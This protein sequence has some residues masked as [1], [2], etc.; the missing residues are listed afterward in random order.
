MDDKERAALVTS[1]G[2]EGGA[3]T[4]DVCGTEGHSNAPGWTYGADHARCPEHPFPD[5][6]RGTHTP[7]RTP[8]PSSQSGG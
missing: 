4:C 7:L 1:E 5:A 2:A 6:D 8:P 3:L